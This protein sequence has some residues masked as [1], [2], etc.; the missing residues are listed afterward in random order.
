MNLLHDCAC[1]VGWGKVNSQLGHGNEGID[2]VAHE[3]CNTGNVRVFLACLA[4]QLYIL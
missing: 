4:S 2:R 3:R 1:V